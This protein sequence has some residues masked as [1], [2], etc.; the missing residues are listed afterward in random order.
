[1]WPCWNAPPET[2]EVR[3]QIYSG[4][5]LNRTGYVEGCGWE[6]WQA[7]PDLQPEPVFFGSSTEAAE[8][9]VV[10]NVTQFFQVANGNSTRCALVQIV[11]CSD[12]ACTGP[13]NY[14]GSFF[15]VEGSDL[16]ISKAAPL[17]FDGYIGTWNYDGQAATVPFKVE[18]CGWAQWYV[19]NQ[20]AQA[21]SVLADLVTDTSACTHE[22]SMLS[23]FSKVDV[24]SQCGEPTFALCSD[25]L[26]SSQVTSDANLN[27]TG[28]VLTVDKCSARVPS[29]LFLAVLMPGGTNITHPLQVEVCGWHEYSLS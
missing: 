3:Q 20:S 21:Y 7:N 26:C 14:S 13:K 25:Q 19:T 11:L 24:T 29:T 28:D 4:E 23:I 27:L 22:V 15:V 6:T 9:H 1:M 18:I 2:Y 17:Y 10:S 16:R 8:W 12:A 5:W